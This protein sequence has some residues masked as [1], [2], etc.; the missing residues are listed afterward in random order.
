MFTRLLIA[1][2]GEIACRIAR[3]CR[4]LGIEVIAVYSDADAG[5]RHV[6]EADAAARIGAAPARDSYLNVEAIMQAAVE[7]GVQA[8]H[9][10]YG[11]LSEKL[12]LI[13]AC[14]RAGIVFVGPKRDAIA[15]MGSKIESKRIARA[16]GVACLPGYDGDDQSE[17]PAGRSRQRRRLV[18]RHA[19]RTLLRPASH[20]R[21]A[22][23]RRATAHRRSA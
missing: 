9:P 16:V 20:R 22:G 18:G 13:D 3:T 11:F 23:S 6:R 8:I 1:N 15:S 21:R 7:H 17:G 19:A 5:A 10:G 4:R 14:A 12:E 2:R